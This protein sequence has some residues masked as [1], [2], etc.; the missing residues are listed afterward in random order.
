MV[1]SLQF[2]GYCVVLVSAAVFQGDQPNAVVAAL[3][4]SE[5]HSIMKK[6]DFVSSL[7]VV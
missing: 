4:K 6:N 5:L 7:L 2:L 1:K 3:Y